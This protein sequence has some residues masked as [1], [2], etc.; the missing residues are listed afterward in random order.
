MVLKPHEAKKFYDRFGKRQDSQSFYEDKAT[1]DLIAHGDFG[2]AAN[3]FEF[4]C[5]TGR[6]AERLLTAH[7]PASA[8]Y[9]GYDLSSTM[10]GLA[11]QR[12]AAFK[13]RMQVIQTDGT[14]RFLVGDSSVDRIV[15]AYVL[16]L[17]SA[18]DISAFFREAYR[19]LQIGGKI[20]LVGLTTGTT[21]DP[22]IVTAAWF[23]IFRMRPSLVGGCRPVRLTR[24]LDTNL[25]QLGYHRVATAFGI[26]SEVLVAGIKK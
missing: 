26:P 8:T 16:D 15:S 3:V 9:T 18:T 1:N 10:V 19:I 17:L 13:A 23:S 11:G 20:G 7:L 22:R 12:L 14:I 6:F 2:E 24:F 21:W 25:W 5:G 4:G